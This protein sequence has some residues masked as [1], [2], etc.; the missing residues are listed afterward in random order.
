MATNIPR[1][2]K[3]L[4]A[5]AFDQFTD[6]DGH[7]TT[8]DKVLRAEVSDPSQLEVVDFDATLGTVGFARLDASSMEVQTVAVVCD[9]RK[10]P[11]GQPDEIVE[12]RLEAPVTTLDEDAAAGVLSLNV[13]AA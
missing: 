9:A 6:A 11:V 1:G 13:V 4:G 7:P 8:I 10:Q 5:V 3:A 2:M 12:L